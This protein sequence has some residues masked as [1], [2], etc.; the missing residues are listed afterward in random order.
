MASSFQVGDRANVT[1]LCATIRFIGKTQ[2]AEGE[3]IGVELDEEKG[4]NN[5]SVQGVQYF[6]CPASKGMFVRRTALEVYSPSTSPAKRASRTKKQS[7]KGRKST[8]ELDSP[9]APSSSSLDPS[10]HPALQQSLLWPQPAKR[11]SLLNPG[12]RQSAAFETDISLNESDEL[13]EKVRGMGTQV[14][15]LEQIIQSLSARLDDAAMLETAYATPPEIFE[16]DPSELA[17]EMEPLLVNAADRIAEQFQD[18]LDDI[19]EEQLREAMA[20]QIHAI[21]QM[22]GQEAARLSRS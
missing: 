5:G 18:K 4:K 11:E 13:I 22:L 19:L 1:G 8:N 6:E 21:E 14:A 17:P 20:P 15:K 16:K 12:R 7:L 3:W 10:L 2:F 9:S